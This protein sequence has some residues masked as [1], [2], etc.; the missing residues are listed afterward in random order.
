MDFGI[1][2][3]DSLPTQ[4]ALKLELTVL[5]WKGVSPAWLMSSRLYSSSVLGSSCPEQRNCCP[6]AFESRQGAVNTTHRPGCSLAITAFRNFNTESLL[7][8]RSNEPGDNNQASC[9]ASA[10]PKPKVAPL[11]TH[12]GQPSLLP[13]GLE[14]NNKSIYLTGMGQHLSL[15]LVWERGNSGQHPLGLG[16]KGDQ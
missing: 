1:F 4:R 6:M 7:A 16:K 12:T 13:P 2:R 9:G 8:L 5:V 3:T 10:F 14:L 11:S 15:P